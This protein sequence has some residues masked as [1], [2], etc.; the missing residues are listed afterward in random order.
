M[1]EAPAPHQGVLYTSPVNLKG[2]GVFSP[3]AKRARQDSNL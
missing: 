3:E 2:K 1:D